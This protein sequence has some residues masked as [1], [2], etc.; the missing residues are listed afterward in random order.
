MKRQAFANLRILQGPRALQ[1][2]GVVD[3]HVW[4]PLPF[5]RAEASTTQTWI[6]CTC[7]VSRVRKCEEAPRQRVSQDGARRSED[8]TSNSPVEANTDMNAF[9]QRRPGSLPHGSA[10][11]C[12][13]TQVDCSAS[14]SSW[15]I[16]D[17]GLRRSCRPVLEKPAVCGSWC[18][19]H[20][21]NFRRARHTC[22][23][24]GTTTFCVAPADEG[25][26]VC[27]DGF[28]CTCAS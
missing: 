26:A 25:E 19:K 12:E 18:F 13:R 21:Q 16:G 14:R 4:V 22:G 9:K 28:F 2:R 24:G 7:V 3:G 11:A 23:S 8:Q 10:G 5:A 1:Q 27:C 6:N 20:P 17:D 15:C